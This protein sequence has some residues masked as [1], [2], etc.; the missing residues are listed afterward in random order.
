MSPQQH[1]YLAA[2]ETLWRA[3]ATL[4]AEQ[5]LTRLHLHIYAKLVCWRQ[6]T[7]RHRDL[8]RAAHCSLRTVKRALTRL[9]AN[10]LLGWTRRVVRGIG[11]RAQISNAYAFSSMP[12]A[13]LP[14]SK[15]LVLR[16]SAKMAPS[17]LPASD[18]S[19]HGGLQCS[20]QQVQA[21]RAALLAV[22]ERNEA[23]QRAEYAARQRARWDR[24]APHP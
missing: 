1:A 13:S 10:G 14:S 20:H 9:R 22:S 12:L 4:T 23:R 2:A 16:S 11:W 6:P 17:G 21:A 5:R 8:A 15:F 3:R 24:A 18:L 7:P 19:A